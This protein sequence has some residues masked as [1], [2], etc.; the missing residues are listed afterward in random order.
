MKRIMVQCRTA[1]DRN[2]VRRETIDGVEHVIISSSTL[3]D[4]IVMNGGLYPA[5]EIAKSFESLELTLAPVEHPHI[6]GQFISASDPRAIHEFHAGAFN[7]NVRRENGRVHVDKCI[8]VTEARKT[9]RGKRLLDRIDELENSSDPR[10]IHTSV[11]VFLMPEELSEPKT[12]AEGDEFTWVARDMVFD[13]DAILLDSTGAAQPHQGVGMAVNSKGEEIEVQVNTI[14]AS[15]RLPLAPSDTTWDS[16]EAIK[17]VREAIGAEDEPN[18]TYGRYHLWFDSE[19]SENFGAYKLP[20]VD[21]IDGEAMAVP[22][23]LRNASARLNQTDGPSDAERERIRGIIDGYLNELK[24]NQSVSELHSAVMDALERAAFDAGFIEELFTDRVIFWSKD[25][26]FEVPFMLDPEGAATIVGIPVPV[27]REVTYIPKTNQS[28]GDAM[29]ELMLKA[30]ADAGITVNAEISDDELLAKYN[31]LQANQSEGGDTGVEITNALQS[32]TQKIDGLEAKMNSVET[33]ELD[34]LA[35]VVA[36]SG[37]YPGMDAEAAK[38][39]GVDKL[40]ELAANC[41][42]AFGL[43]PVINSGTSEA[44]A[45]PA[46]MPE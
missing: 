30:L 39:L 33:A 21:I 38:L 20:F 37:K 41:Q 7:I 1:V 42:S 46:D 13:H 22:N 25:Q 28:E 26:L 32:L 5:D 45:A 24:D 3:P 18:A 12:N 36:N 9:D 44:H 29:K 34:R 10:P 4:D 11:G 35:E 31:E 2:A 23:A 43:S 6:N 17:R 8:N 16:G 27:N 40:K 14:T 15:R 19:Q